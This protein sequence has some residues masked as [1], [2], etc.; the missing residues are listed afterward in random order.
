MTSP[1][2]KNTKQKTL[3]ADLDRIL[4]RVDD[5]PDLDSRTPDEIIG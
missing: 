3:E 4:R 2:E 5:M 1:P